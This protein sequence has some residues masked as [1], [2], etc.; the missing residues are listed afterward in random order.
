MKFLFSNELIF[1]TIN[2]QVSRTHRRNNWCSGKMFL[3][4][5]CKKLLKIFFF[6]LF[7]IICSTLAILQWSF[8]YWAFKC[9][10]F[11]YWSF[12]FW[13]FNCFWIFKIYWAFKCWTTFCEHCKYLPNFHFTL[14][15]ITLYISFMFLF[16]FLK[17]MFWL[18]SIK[19]AQK[20]VFLIKAF[21]TT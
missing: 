15:V 9:W 17:T 14:L 13:Y 20:S 5:C 12:K 1:L 19:P 6:N 4:L 7:C 2:F 10:A 11:M 21:V 16:I 8:E 18:K 3:R